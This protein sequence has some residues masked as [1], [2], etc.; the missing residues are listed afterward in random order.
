MRR[1]TEALSEVEKAHGV[2]VLYACE[3]G[4]R[5]WGFESPDSD[6]D[7]RFLY[8]RSL[9]WYLSIN[10]ENKSDTIEQTD[11]DL[12]L[13]GWDLRKAMMLFYKSNP[14][15]MEWL[16]S[17]VVYR[18]PAPVVEKMQSLSKSFYNFNSA[19]YHYYHMASGN[20]KKY[21]DGKSEAWIKKYFY[22][23]RPLL[24]VNWM[25]TYGTMPPVKFLSMF[26]LLPVEVQP[27][28]ADLLRQK[29]AGAEL[30]RGERLSLLHEYLT[31][32]LAVKPEPGKQ[33]TLA[34]MDLLNKLFRQA[35]SL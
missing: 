1:V 21:L 34:D 25:Q 2:T 20:F 17:P 33:R 11:G 28:V 15:L 9:D 14:P 35:L 12:D 6:Y 23:L 30:R 13:S 16:N 8:L 10:L 26:H 31:T 32:M 19:A 3:N 24:C 27:E 7:V 5:A 4:S 22:V 18:E 29:R